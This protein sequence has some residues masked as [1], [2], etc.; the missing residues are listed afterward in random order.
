M[1]M[2]LR[3]DLLVEAHAC[4]W[5]LLHSRTSL[6]IRERMVRLSLGPPA[7]VS[8]RDVSGAVVLLY[9]KFETEGSSWSLGTSLLY[10][11]QM[12]LPIEAEKQ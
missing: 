1:E 2:F 12:I 5:S 3:G 6:R 7:S 9:R 4:S 10:A 11:T 8:P